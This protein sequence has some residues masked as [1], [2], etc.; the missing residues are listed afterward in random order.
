MF[1]DLSSHSRKTFKKINEVQQL[2]KQLTEANTKLELANKLLLKSDRS[3]T[4]LKKHIKRLKGINKTSNTQYYH[5]LEAAIKK[6][7]NEDQI[8]VL[9][10]Q[11]SCYRTWSNDTIRKALRLK[12][13]CGSSGYQELLKG[14]MPLPSERTLR[15]KLEN[16][17]FQEGISDDIFN[18]LEDKVAQFKDVRDRDCSLVL[19]EMSIA[20]GQQFNSSTQSYCGFASFCTRN[21]MHICQHSANTI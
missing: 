1:A 18:L 19:D 16:I 4:V 21:G 6:V 9:M 2:K 14:N 13:S 12:F 17:Q 11:S 7:F 8:A 15:R 5:T 20:P 3:R 10:Q